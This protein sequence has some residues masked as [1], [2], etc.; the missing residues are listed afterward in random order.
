MWNGTDD[1]NRKLP[2][3]VYFLKFTAGDY[4]ATQKL[5]LIR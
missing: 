2:S 1:T 4:T 3:G 5:L